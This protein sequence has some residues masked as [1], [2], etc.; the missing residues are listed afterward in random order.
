MP[1]TRRTMLA[2]SLGSTVALAGC[3]GIVESDPE[4][5]DL[6]LYNYSDDPQPLK[7]ELLP[8]GDGHDDEGQID[9]FSI[10]AP[11][12]AERAGSIR[13]EG[14]VEQRRYLVRVLPQN[15]SGLRHH[16]HFVPDT[17]ERLIVRLYDGSEP[18][19]FTV[20]FR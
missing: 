15:G 12:D 11:S 17:D 1:S 16:G 14:F 13:R 20:R 5:T 7:L 4:M 6:A 19:T 2:G 8:D 10:P 9:E 18:G 3:L